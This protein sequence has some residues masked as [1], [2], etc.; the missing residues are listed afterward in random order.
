[1][2]LDWTTGP[3][4]EGLR[5]YDA[6]QFW[7]AH[8]SWEQ[9]WLASPEPQKTFLQSLIQTTAACH[10]LQRNNALGASRLFQNALRR[11]EP[12]PADF[13]GIAVASLRDDL[14]DRIARLAA[15]QPTATIAPPRIVPICP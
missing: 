5:L 12:L 8:E 7:H 13:G 2:S 10:H 6:G 4:A 11:I 14:R 1:M 15:S 9:V 3:L